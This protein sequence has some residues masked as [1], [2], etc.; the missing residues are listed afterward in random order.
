M[1][2][3]KRNLTLQLNAV[4]GIQGELKVIQTFLFFLLFSCQIC[5][6]YDASLDS[7]SLSHD[8]GATVTAVYTEVDREYFSIYR[9]AQLCGGG[10]YWRIWRIN[11]HLPI[12]Y[13]P[14]FSYQ[15]SIFTLKSKFAHQSLEISLFANIFPR[16]IIALYGT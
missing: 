2:N 16:C 9:I 3:V 1:L 12:F 6:S 8:K 7:P 11:C 15:L 14:V 10:K 5:G 4:S 13:L